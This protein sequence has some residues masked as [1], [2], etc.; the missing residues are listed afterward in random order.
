MNFDDTPQEADFRATARKW[1]EANAPKKYETELSK[2]SRPHPAGE[3]RDR[4]CRQG[5]AEE[6]GRR[7]LGLPALAVG[8]WR[9]RRNP[10]REGDLA[11]GRGRLR[12]ADAAVPDRRGHVRPDRDGLGQR[13]AQAPLSAQARLRRAHL[14]PVVL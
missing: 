9:P 8:I 2:S 1:I 5:L 3:G 11:A 7:R 4:R 12:Q 10:D 13:G 14:V 6:E